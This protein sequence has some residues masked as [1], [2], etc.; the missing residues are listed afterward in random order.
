[1]RAAGLPQSVRE[2][3][4]AMVVTSGFQVDMKHQSA[5]GMWGAFLFGNQKYLSVSVFVLTLLA[6]LSWN[7][8]HFLCS[9]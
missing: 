8:S 6:L 7:P 4:E 2:F 9:S 3:E 1:M 5:S